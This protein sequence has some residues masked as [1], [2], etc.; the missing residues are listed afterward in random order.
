M[1]VIVA[2]NTVMVNTYKLKAELAYFYHS[3]IEVYKR[4][5]MENLLLQYILYI[6]IYI[7]HALCYKIYSKLHITCKKT[8]CFT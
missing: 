3:Y 6:L 7:V 4:N 1:L 5:L 2:T 8:S